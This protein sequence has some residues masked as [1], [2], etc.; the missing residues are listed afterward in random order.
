M[1][2]AIGAPNPLAPSIVA[3]LGLSATNPLSWPLCIAIFNPAAFLGTLAA[4]QLTQRFGR[5][6]L[7]TGSSVLYILGGLCFLL[8]SP[9]YQQS[10]QQGDRPDLPD[11]QTR[12]V[13]QAPPSA[14]LLFGTFLAARALVGVAAGAATVVV[15]ACVPVLSLSCAVR[16][17][18]LSLSCPSWCA[19]ALL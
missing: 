17:L 19:C 16:P 12:T 6:V 9:S 15:P 10:L 11:L 18:S 3:S 1:G 5:R 2:F 7:L 13:S 4:A 14:A 8:S